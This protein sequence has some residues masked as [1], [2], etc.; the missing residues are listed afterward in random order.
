VFLNGE[1]VSQYVQG[2]KLIINIG[3]DALNTVTLNFPA[4]IEIP[5]EILSL[6]SAGLDRDEGG[7]G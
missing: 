4:T 3:A 7:T 2:A 5:D 6:V 1:D